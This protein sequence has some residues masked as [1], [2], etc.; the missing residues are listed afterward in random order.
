MF[1]VPDPSTRQGGPEPTSP[2][3]RPRLRQQRAERTHNP[4]WRRLSSRTPRRSQRPARCW[5]SNENETCQRGLRRPRIFLPLCRP[6]KMISWSSGRLLATPTFSDQ[7]TPN[8][9]FRVRADAPAR[10][11]AGRGVPAGWRAGLCRP[12][13][14][15]TR[16]GG[17]LPMT[18]ARPFVPRLCD[19]GSVHGAAIAAP[20]RA[21]WSAG[22]AAATLADPLD[23][24]AVVPTAELPVGHSSV[25]VLRG[26]PTR[27][28]HAH[29]R[30]K[31]DAESRVLTGRIVACPLSWAFVL[32]RLGT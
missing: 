31:A 30:V 21:R 3:R 20:C 28:G 14:R 18:P 9:H 5:P 7:C 17:A 4:S 12:V 8:E 22:P 27:R 19:S 1:P 24:P 32:A 10:P 2:S 16:P 15:R 13:R 23:A 29:F 26:Q 25:D 6:S 11:V